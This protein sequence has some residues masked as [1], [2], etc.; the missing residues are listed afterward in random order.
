[1]FNQC[2]CPDRKGSSGKRLTSAIKMRHDA[3][4]GCG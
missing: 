1:M 3:I 2:K 4:I